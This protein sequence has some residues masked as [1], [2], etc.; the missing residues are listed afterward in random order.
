MSGLIAAPT[1]ARIERQLALITGQNSAWN[2]FTSVM[3]TE[4]LSDADT[5][6]TRHRQNMVIGPLDGLGVAIKDNIDVRGQATTAGI[7]H[8]RGATAAVD[9]PLV[10]RLRAA[11]AVILGKTNLHEAALGVTTDNPWFGRCE[12]PRYPGYTPGGSSGGSAA[13]VAGGLC[14]LALGTDSM[15]SVRIPAAFCGVAGF[16]PTR[17]NID[18]GGI[19]P[20][21]P[22]L[23]T[24]GL[25]AQ[26]ASQLRTAWHGLSGN[27][28][29]DPATAHA[30]RVGVMEIFPDVALNPAVT[31]M[32]AQATTC[33]M[34]AGVQVEKLTPEIASFARLRAD[35]FVLC[36]IDAAAVHA[37]AF[38]ADPAGFS[39]S[40]REMLAYGARQPP[41][42]RVKILERLDE[43]RER[44]LAPFARFD[45]LLLPTTPAP[46]FLHGST[47]PRDVADLTVPANIAGVPAVSIPW[48]TA[49]NGLPLSLQILA[50]PGND[51]SLLAAASLMEQWR[52]AQILKH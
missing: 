36:E 45:F 33:L 51:A 49:A 35:C 42:R 43:A 20:V 21:S 26:S 15:G 7:G 48:R 12:N 22:R 3:Q 18:G 29:T 1:R 39:A 40:L 6:D 8:Y 50:A 13:A 4:A 27:E 52:P 31:L 34:N 17:A 44:L 37:G 46:A 2:I 16:M 38:Q 9:A 14:S 23:D 47:P 32:M 24:P 10:A 5:A 25:L 11:G 30:W 28:Q 41:E 19:T